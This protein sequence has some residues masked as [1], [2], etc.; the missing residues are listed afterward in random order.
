MEEAKEGLDG[1]MMTQTAKHTEKMAWLTRIKRG[2]VINLND[3]LFTKDRDYLI[4]Y[5]D[6]GQVRIV[7]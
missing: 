1:D 6:N 4:R 7:L 2:D 3:L 5:N